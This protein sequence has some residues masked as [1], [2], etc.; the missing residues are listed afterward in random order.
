LEKLR[1]VGLGARSVRAN[2]F[3]SALF[4]F[5]T[6]YFFTAVQG[7]VWYAAHVIGITLAA[8]YLLFSIGA[9]RPM[10]AGL[11]LGLGFMTRSPLLFALPL[12]VFEAVRV[13][14]RPLPG[15]P[16]ALPS[17]AKQL[18]LPLEPGAGE[19]LRLPLASTAP[20]APEAGRATRLAELWRRLD[21]WR[22][23]RLLLQFSLP[24]LFVL[25]VA[26]WHNHARF[27]DPFD[28]GYRYL[29]IRWR[30][31]MDHWGLFDYHYLGRNLAVVLTSLPW[32]V[33]TGGVPFQINAHGLALWLTTPAYLWLLWPRRTGPLTWA[34][35]L[36]V[37]AV[38][39]PTLF[40][41]N[42]G[43]VQFGYRFSNDYAVFLFAL[44]AIGGYRFGAL[45]LAL[46][47]WAMA[48]NAFGALTFERPKYRQF[49]FQDH[50]QRLLHQ[51]D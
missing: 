7:T 42:T 51:P 18:E 48:V 39:V 31:R 40:Y 37:A 44:L 32:T 35:W 19:Q 28:F 23:A 12:F 34:L 9:S 15:L 49:Y 46:A 4:A 38:A 45:F 47:V 43:W 1:L 21:H 33:K 41:Q 24:L 27:G 36:T 3:L 5:G 6:V 20:R 30:A 26:A 14:L 16:P 13:S 2:L 50:T 29:T 10:L 25:V 8:L 17:G 11:V 22:L